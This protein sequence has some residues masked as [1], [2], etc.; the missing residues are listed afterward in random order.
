MP[1][2]ELTSMFRPGCTQR[3]RAETP[4]DVIMLNKTQFIACA[5]RI[6]DIFRGSS[7]QIVEFWAKITLISAY[8]SSI[9]RSSS[10]SSLKPLSVALSS[11]T[12]RTACITVVWSRPPNFR[13]ISGK[14]RAV[15]CF[16]KYIAIWRGRAT[17]RARR[18][19]YISDKR[20]LKCSATRF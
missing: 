20:I 2:E 1:F 18:D 19:E 9:R 16:A 4:C 12:L 3:W 15:N 8:T 13:P 17:A 11:S 14:D 10:T 7:G 5:G 6:C